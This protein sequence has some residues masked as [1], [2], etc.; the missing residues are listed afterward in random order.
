MCYETVARMRWNRGRWLGVGVAA[1]VVAAAAWLARHALQDGQRP[2]VVV[3]VVDTLRADHVG[4]YGYPRPT[5]PTLDALAASGVRFAN[6]RSA[7]SWTAASV[8]SLF[9]GLYP[10]VHGLQGNETVLADG[11]TTVAERFAAHGYATAAFSANAAFVT[12]E[13]GFAQGFQEFHVLHGAEVPADSGEDKIPL[14]ASWRKFA[15]VATADVLTEAAVAWLAARSTR[16]PYFLYVHYFDPHAGYFPPPPYRTRMGVPVD[17][18]LAGP[19]QWKFW[20]DFKLGA[21]RDQ[22]PTLAALYDGEIAFADAEI[23]RLLAAVR[24]HTG[25]P[26]F[27]VVT[28]DHGEEFAEHGDLQHGTSLFEEQVRVPLVVTGPNVP[29]GVVVDAPV[30]L[31]GVAA[32][33]ADL[34]GTSTADAA[35]PP[36]PSFAG[37]V[38]GDRGAAPATAIFADLFTTGARHHQMIVDGRFKLLRFGD[39]QQLYDL[40]AD[41]GEH[42][43]LAPTDAADLQRLAA[44]LD[45]REQAAALVR[46]A[47]GTVPSSE[48]RRARLKALGYVQ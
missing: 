35:P 34:T 44:A 46:V 21:N 1:V 43:D 42:R 37:A 29:P 15:K 13:Q 19:A 22:L 18:P 24:E 9:T 32:T 17:A 3:V 6:V 27:V 2:S 28:S 5:S 11:L 47:P 12:P 40:A 4:C 41:P 38:R 45:A 48:L 36:A 10:A 31:V 25:A 33:L 39:A 14:D 30:S 23:G 7:S 16:D 8:A 26:P 20:I